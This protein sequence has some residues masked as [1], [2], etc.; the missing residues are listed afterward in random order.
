MGEMIR[1]NKECLKLVSL[2]NYRINKKVNYRIY[3]N[4]FPKLITES[5]FI[6]IIIFD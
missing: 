1:T 4:L 2:I 6:Q 5:V 3:F